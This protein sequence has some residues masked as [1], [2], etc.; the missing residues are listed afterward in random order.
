MAAMAGGDARDGERPDPARILTRRDFAAALTRLRAL[1]RLAVR[2]VA[3]AADVPDGT[4]GDYFAGRHLPPLRPER[5]PGILRAC[6]VRDPAEIAGWLEALRRVR[7]RPGPRSEETRAPYLGLRSFQVEDAEWFFGRE[8][9]TAELV[10]RVRERRAGVLAVTGPSGS[11][12]SSLL[13]AGLIPALAGTA[14]P[15]LVT[16]G[17][18]P[19]GE[20]AARLADLTGRTDVAEVRREPAVAATED[21]VVVVDQFEEVFTDGCA[22]ADRTAYLRALRAIAARPPAAVVIGLRADF[23][24]RALRHPE[25]AEILQNS[26]VGVGPMSEAELRQAILSPARKAGAA[27]GGGRGGRR[28]AD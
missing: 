5:L 25:L 22:E 26:Q 11:G 14:T 18:D 21:L 8:T 23:Y 7:P 9:L 19:V 17:T 24:A 15:L 13:R 28:S 16:P 1:G 4:M 10:A 27:R 20:L 3:K 2:D 6:G 12:K